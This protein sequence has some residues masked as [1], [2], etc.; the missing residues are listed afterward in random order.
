MA[1]QHITAPQYA[2][3][4]VLTEDSTAEAMAFLSVDIPLNLFQL[5]WLENYGIDSPRKADAFVFLGVRT[6]RGRLAG[7]ALLV[8]RSLL[9][10]HSPEAGAAEALGRWV[11]GQEV[12][13]DHLVSDT[14]SVDA[15]WRG[16]AHADAHLEDPPA[17]LQAQTHRAQ[18]LYTLERHRWNYCNTL[19]ERAAAG[20]HP[21]LARLDE[22]DAV[23]LAS[24]RMHREETNIDPLEDD[25]DAFRR[26][27]AHR[28]S[29]GRCYVHFDAHRRLLFKAELSAHSRFGAQVSGVY[30]DPICRQ[31]GI[32]TAALFDICKQ[33][34][35]GG[36]RRVTLYVNDDN[37]AAHRVYRKV[38][39]VPH[40]PYQTI[41][42]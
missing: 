2:P 42:V 15:F 30:T 23:F 38:G 17:P 40:A 5:S 13:L 19:P 3:P 24:V 33:L 11:R 39:F 4:E 34:F 25:P 31:K 14:P 10:V 41:F 21:R 36:A 20:V 6:T 37:E 1:I 8:G 9:L 7:V 22:I 27:V 32:A 28:I 18:M 12:H 35:E 16:Y 29:N 26:H